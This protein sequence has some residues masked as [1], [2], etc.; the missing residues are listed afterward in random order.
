MAF[1]DGDFLEIEY[2]ASTTSDGAVIASTDEQKAKSAGIYSKENYYGPVLVILGTNSVIKGL[3]A[4]LH[5]MG[6][7]EQKKFDF[8]AGEAFGERNEDLVRVMPI[9]EFRKNEIDPKPGMQINIDNTPV[10]VKSVNSGRVVVDANHPFAGKDVT[11]EVK[12]VKQLT[13]DN[14]K[15]DSLGKTYGAKPSKVEVKDK[16]ALISYNN[17]VSKNADYFIGRAN[18]LASTFANIKDIDK[19]LVEEEYERPKE[20]PAKK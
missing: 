11:Y 2:T 17:G 6:L 4:A 16:K 9:T 5:S 7:N 10:L 19:I 18:M 20:E 3:D 14:E 15:I 1:K 12:V 8:K 13:S